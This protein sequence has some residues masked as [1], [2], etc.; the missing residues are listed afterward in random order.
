MYPRRGISAEFAAIKDL[1]ERFPYAA[2]AS[3]AANRSIRIDND[4]LFWY[5]PATCEY[6]P[7]HPRGSLS[8]LSFDQSFNSESTSKM[9]MLMTAVEQTINRAAEP[10]L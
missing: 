6:R 8:I 4:E 1:I 2:R 7:D 5:R 3:D 9:F 10:I